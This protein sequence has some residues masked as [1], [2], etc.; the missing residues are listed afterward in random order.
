MFQSGGEVI[1]C[2]KR[3][4]LEDKNEPSEVQKR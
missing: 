3:V 2:I 1:T 4:N